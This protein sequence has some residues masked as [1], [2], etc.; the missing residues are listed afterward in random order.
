MLAEGRGE[1]RKVLRMVGR[2][3]TAK[4]VKRQ[5]HTGK[6]GIGNDSPSG[7]EASRLGSCFSVLQSFVLREPSAQHFNE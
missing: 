3:K 6:A 4:L 7:G 1:G 5:E 2:K